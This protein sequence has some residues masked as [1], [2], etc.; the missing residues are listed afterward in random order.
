L[1]RPEYAQQRLEFNSGDILLTRGISFFSAALSRIPDPVGQFSHFVLLHKDD[2]N[3]VNSIESYAQTGGVSTFSEAEALKNE[4]SRILLLRPRDGKL[5]KAAADWMMAEISKRKIGYDF[6]MDIAEPNKMICAEVSYHAYRAASGNTFN[7][8]ESN[9]LVSKK[10]A[11]FVKKVG[12]KADI[13]LSPRD[14]ELD[15]RFEMIAEFKDYRILRDLR[16]RDAILSKIYQWMMDEQYELHNDILTG[17]LEYVAWPSRNTFLFPLMQK[18]SFGKIP[19]I[20]PGTPRQFFATMAQLNQASE[21]IYE[22]LLLL[23]QQNIKNTGWHMTTQQ[24]S[25]A[26]EKI[27]KEDLADY[28][29]DYNRGQKFH[30]WLRSKNQFP[31]PNNNGS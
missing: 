24:L 1:I 11:G 18:I 17:T 15:S 3:N 14:M 6:E 20:P 27:R 23:D 19:D 7:L 28:I 30:M 21:I 26:I 13:I 5:G 25:S 8:P 9:S 31:Q 29:N 12:M 4:N 10:L 16:Y 22:Q 2:K